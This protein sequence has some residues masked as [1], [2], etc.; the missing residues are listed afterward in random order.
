[1]GRGR[2]ITAIIAIMAAIAVIYVAAS[3][4]G[5]AQQSMSAFAVNGNTYRISAY[6]YTQ[7]QQEKGLMNST[8][9]NSTFML[10]YFGK[11]GIYPFWMK[12][13][14]SQLDI[15]WLNYSAATHIARVVY[16]VNATPCIDYDK[17]QAN[18]AVYIPTA[19]SNYVLETKSGFV[20]SENISTGTELRFI[21]GS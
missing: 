12:D 19:Y 3:F 17:S 13:T 18:C 7:S 2:K 16:M 10:F 6:A 8:V 5:S 1:M 9:T 11:H 21:G 14:Y 20:N 15:I 4:A